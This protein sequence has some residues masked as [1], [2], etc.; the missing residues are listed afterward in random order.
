MLLF[1]KKDYF[2]PDADGVSPVIAFVSKA[3]TVKVY[4]APA[5]VGRDPQADVVINDA[6][7]SRKHLLIGTYEGKYTATDQGST[8]GTI[9]NGEKLEPGYPYYLS[10]GDKVTIGKLDFVCHINKEKAIGKISLPSF[11]HKDTAADT[12]E[13]AKSDIDEALDAAESK[14]AE[15]PLPDAEPVI[16]LMKDAEEEIQAEEA[17]EPLPDSEPVIQLMKQPEIEETEQS[18][19]AERN[20]EPE[21]NDPITELEEMGLEF[22]DENEGEAYAIESNLKPEAPAETEA[23]VASVHPEAPAETEAPA[24][25][26][27][28]EA[29]A[30]AE[31]PAPEAGETPVS[32]SADTPTV[33]EAPLPAPVEAPIPSNEATTVLAGGT[34]TGSEHAHGSKPKF[35]YYSGHTAVET[36]EI[37]ATPFVIGRGKTDYTPGAAGVSRKHCFIDKTGSTYYITDLESTNGVW[38]NGRKIKPY[39][40]TALVNGDII[41]IGDRVYKYE[42]TI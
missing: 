18:E 32:G 2:K 35:V 22:G 24:A 19:E 30:D 4:K 16:Q 11:M 36:F 23:P 38:I 29:P 42:Q 8:V 6:A 33:D 1:G 28:P 14:A 40:R 25:S 7:V 21:Q 3:K 34:T 9:I 31:E 41:G 39:N 20:E 37:T 15:E 10:E 12:S 27:E 26:T 17:A 13:M 5:L